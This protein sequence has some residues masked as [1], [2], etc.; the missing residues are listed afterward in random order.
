M[1][2]S[3]QARS[4]HT[5]HAEMYLPGDLLALSV[6][7]GPHDAGL[8]QVCR[9]LLNLRQRTQ[10]RAECNEMS[11]ICESNDRVSDLV[12]TAHVESI[13]KKRTVA[14]RLG[15]G[16]RRGPDTNPGRSHGKR[17]TGLDYLYLL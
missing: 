2:S 12:R 6:D 8:R 17:S 1:C 3:Y 13:L 4:F 10:R 11:G 5:R 9:N 14:C 16:D 15:V 7:V